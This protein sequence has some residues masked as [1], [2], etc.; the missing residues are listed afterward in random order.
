MVQ[1]L[2][3]RCLVPFLFVSA[4]LYFLQ[5]DHPAAKGHNGPDRGN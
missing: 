5:D 3:V 4:S 2:T 1:S